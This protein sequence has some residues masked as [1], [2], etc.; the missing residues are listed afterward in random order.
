MGRLQMLVFAVLLK[1][2]ATTAIPRWADLFSALEPYKDPVE[3]ELGDPRL[4]FVQ[5]EHFNTHDCRH[6][7][8]QFNFISWIPELLPLMPRWT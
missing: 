1:S 7:T 3:E 8:T 2:S 6:F 4:G 5:V